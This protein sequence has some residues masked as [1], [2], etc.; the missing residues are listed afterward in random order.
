MI[1]NNFEQQERMH[2]VEDEGGPI[3]IIDNKKDIKFIY[4]IRNILCNRDVQWVLSRK[5][6]KVY[7]VLQKKETWQSWREIITNVYGEIDRC[8]SDILYVKSDCLLQ[9]VFFSE[10]IGADNYTRVFLKNKGNATA[11]IHD[12]LGDIKKYIFE[13]KDLVSEVKSKLDDSSH[14]R[15]MALRESSFIQIDIDAKSALSSNSLA[16][17]T[18]LKKINKCYGDLKKSKESLV[19]SIKAIKQEEISPESRNEI[20]WK[21]Q[22]LEKKIEK[23][24]REINQLMV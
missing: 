17:D 13:L 19:Y 6:K 10:E 9:K 15:E 23:N 12:C 24:E 21:I 22:S 20:Q 16:L 1:K 5:L 2:S 7:N 18:T 3:H 11:Y 4:A 14:L 8:L